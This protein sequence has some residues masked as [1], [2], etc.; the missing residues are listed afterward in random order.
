MFDYDA[1]PVT[2]QVVLIGHRTSAAGYAIRDF[3]SRNGWPYE[4]IDADDQDRVR[5]YLD[6]GEITPGRLPIC[7]LPDGN[8]L[9]PATVE[10]V[11]AGLGMV[12]APSLSEYDLTIVGAGPRAWLPRSTRRRKVCAPWPWRRWRPAARPVPPR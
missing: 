5:V 10:E 6:P 12:T 9:A 7:V 1:R 8:R 4:W 2:P 11:A 3:L